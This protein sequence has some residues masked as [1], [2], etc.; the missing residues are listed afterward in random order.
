MLDKSNIIEIRKRLTGWRLS[1]PASKMTT[2]SGRF[3][4]ILRIFGT[5][6]TDI[7]QARA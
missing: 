4:I 5:I 1:F 2:R 6:N 3:R 7:M